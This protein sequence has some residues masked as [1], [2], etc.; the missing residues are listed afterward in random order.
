[1]DVYI[2]GHEDARNVY[3]VHQNDPVTGR[4]DEDKVMLGFYT[5]AD[6]K[7]AYL[8][9]YDRPGFLGEI[10]ILPLEEFREKVLSKK[11]HGKTV[12]SFSERVLESLGGWF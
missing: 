8:K 7:A 12:K 4:Y 5:L 3:I 9:Q 11:Y 2:G 6:A 10:D 1:V